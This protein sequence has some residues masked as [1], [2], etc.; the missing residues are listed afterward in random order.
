MPR[1]L[2]VEEEKVAVVVQMVEPDLVPGLVVAPALVRVVLVA[3]GKPML[4]VM[5]GVRAKV[6]APMGLADK[7]PE[8]VVGKEKV[9]VA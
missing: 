9:R 4:M 5:A 8:R 1:E 3:M 6:L 7:E 2:V